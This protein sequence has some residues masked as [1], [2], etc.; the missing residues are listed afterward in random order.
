MSSDNAEAAM[1]K[2]NEYSRTMF[3]PKD[4]KRKKQTTNF[5]SIV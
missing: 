3:D 1:M 2:L 5:S 4:S